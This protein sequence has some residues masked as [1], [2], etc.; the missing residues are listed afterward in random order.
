LVRK[1]PQ[2]CYDL[3]EAIAVRTVMQL[4]LNFSAYLTA[5]L[6]SFGIEGFNASFGNNGL[7]YENLYNEYK[8]RLRELLRPYYRV[9]MSAW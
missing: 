4:I 5:G 7:L 1:A 8:A 6:K 9:V 3:L 2:I